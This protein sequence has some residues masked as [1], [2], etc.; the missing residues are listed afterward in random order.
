MPAGSAVSAAYAFRWFRTDGASR[1]VA[2]TVMILSGL[3]SFG[4]LSL[5]SLAGG[6]AAVATRVAQMWRTTR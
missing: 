1:S 2:A 5:L 4:A 6:A 3:L